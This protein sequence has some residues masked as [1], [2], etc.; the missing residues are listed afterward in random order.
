MK[1]G[2][3]HSLLHDQMKLHI[4]NTNCFTI[5]KNSGS[6]G[7]T[8]PHKSFVIKSP[9]HQL[10]TSLIF[11]RTLIDYV[12]IFPYPLPFIQCVHTTSTSK[13]PKGPGTLSHPLVSPASQAPTVF[14][15][16][17]YP[18]I[19]HFPHKPSLSLWS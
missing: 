18:F 3:S 8:R 14:Y 4:C 1:N 11:G 17:L 15:R 10:C 9:D 6:H 19:F 2:A 12:C 16:L 7:K 5:S 13:C